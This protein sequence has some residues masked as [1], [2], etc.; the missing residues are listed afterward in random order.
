MNNLDKLKELTNDLPA[1]PKLN[2]LVIERDLTNHSIIY[3]VEDGTSF[4]FGLLNRPQVSVQEL[5]VSKGTSFPAHLHKEENEWGI[6][7]KGEMKVFLGDKE[8]I[9]KAGECVHFEKGVI[10]SSQALT[11]C[12]LI[13]VGVPKIKGFPE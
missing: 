12:W 8:I 1:V 10:H 6:L 5:F 9:L 2:D 7:Y 3:D 13:A 4:G 11:D